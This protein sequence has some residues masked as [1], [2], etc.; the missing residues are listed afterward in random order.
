M[1]NFEHSLPQGYHEVYS[2]DAQDKKTVVILNVMSVVLVLVAI[3]PLF[4]ILLGTSNTEF[5][6]PFTGTDLPVLFSLCIAL[7]MYLLLHELAHGAAYY[8]LTKQKL[9]YGF[10]LSVAFCGVPQIYVYRRAALI[11]TLTPFVVFS[12]LFLS[13][14]LFLPTLNWKLAAA[15][16]F[17]VH[18]GGC[19]GDLYNTILLL[20]KFKGDILV[21]DTGPKQT[22]YAKDGN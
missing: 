16:L 21:Q 3:I 22:F 14:I 15:L 10:T 9:T 18:F 11:A 7:V 8:L 12:I 20:F 2:I 19:V 6:F 4:F 17:G 5:T 13:A 1:K